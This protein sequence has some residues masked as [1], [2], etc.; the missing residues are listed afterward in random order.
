MNV[1]E[2]NMIILETYNGASQ[3]WGNDL[4]HLQQ[5]ASDG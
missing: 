2:Q 3:R 5:A 4:Q 1:Y